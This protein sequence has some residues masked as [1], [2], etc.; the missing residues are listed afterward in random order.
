M[1]KS[2][3]KIL[4]ET[5][6]R[7]EHLK[8]E[9]AEFFAADINW[10]LG[11]KEYFV[12]VTCPACDS[13][14]SQGVFEK[15]G[16]LYEIC[17]DCETMYINPRPTPSILEKYYIRSENYQY[18]KK[19]IFP[20]SEHARRDKIFR[21]RAEKV[22]DICQR[23]NVGGGMLL[24][25]GAGYG[26]FCEEIGKTG[27]FQRIIAVEPTPD[28]AELCRQRGLEVIEK[29]VEKLSLEDVKIDVMVSFEVIEHLFSPVNFVNKCASII[30]PGGMLIITCPNVK[31]FDI[32]T[33]QDVS[34]SIDPEHLNYFNPVSLSNMISKC[35]FEIVEVL[36]PGKL[37]A[38]LV[39]K[40]VLSGEF[41]ISLQPFL[42]HIL[43]YEWE[44]VGDAFQQFLAD[45]MLSSHMW[46]VAR[47][48]Q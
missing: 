24:E 20:A 42:E 40:K 9:Q 19:H 48:S 37:D 30:N 12:R 29:P 17:L 5:E 6:I 32:L 47:K 46:V 10:L 1:N 36:T 2:N 35:N 18:W 25:V 43:I 33:L 31:G 38:E 41:D 14:K 23:Y 28:L 45:N 4:R 13:E 15:Y 16:F 39:R 11:R 22:I 3:R 44:R 34:D 8:K 26:T 27:F 7:P 21:P